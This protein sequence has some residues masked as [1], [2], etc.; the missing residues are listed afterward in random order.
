MKTPLKYVGS[1]ASLVGQI[2]E[3]MPCDTTA[4]VEP[5][6]GSGAFSF[7]SGL[8]FYLMDSQP[9]LINF[10]E[11]LREDRS[12][13][14]SKLRKMRR[15]HNKLDFVARNE[16]F[17]SIRG[18]DRSPLEFL[19]MSNI[20][21]AARYYYIVYTGFNGIF[22]VNG[23]NQCNTP[24]GKRDFNI[25]ASSLRSASRCLRD[26][27]G[28]VFHQ[29]FDD[30]GILES[31]VDSDAKPFVLIDPPYADGDNGRPVYRG[32]TPDKIDDQFYDRLTDYMVSL[33]DAGVPFLMTN[34]YCKLITTKF[35][36]WE[37][38]KVP[39]K[40]TVGTDGTR[41]GEKFE[42]FISNREYLK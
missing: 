7:D 1:K 38:K 18:Q 31:I 25:N 17:L 15:E 12:R 22:R 41:R 16:Y 11:V 34:T 13:L 39:V 26:R 37:I 30:M 8:P 2:K 4:I 14:L 19:R 21:R 35:S 36:R 23:N 24:D 9:E 5:F 28:G 6:A 32:Y 20:D 10:Y 40:Y 29:Q 33:T 3:Y 42:A 27:C